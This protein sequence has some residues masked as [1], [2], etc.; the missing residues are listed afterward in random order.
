VVALKPASSPA[1]IG[2]RVAATAIRVAAS[3]VGYRDRGHDRAQRIAKSLINPAVNGEGCAIPP[4][5]VGQVVGIVAEPSEKVVEGSVLHHDHHDCVDG[6]FGHGM[7]EDAGEPTF[8]AAAALP[9]V[10]VPAVVSAAGKGQAPAGG[11]ASRDTGH[12]EELTPVHHPDRPLGQ[13]Q[14]GARRPV[15]AG[16]WGGAAGTCT[17]PTCAGGGWRWRPAYRPRQLHSDPASLASRWVG[18]VAHRGNG[19]SAAGPRSSSVRRGGSR[20]GLISNRT[21]PARCVPAYRSD[22][23]RRTSWSWD[24]PGDRGAVQLG[25][26]DRWRHSLSSQ[27]GGT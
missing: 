17:R 1:V 23:W 12:A 26:R 22:G 6:A 9:G 2:V 3:C 27:R 10:V 16:G 24:S 4:P 21:G 18:S 5:S 19:H 8:A 14:P 15:A 20:S 13:L 7:V 11:C 25:F